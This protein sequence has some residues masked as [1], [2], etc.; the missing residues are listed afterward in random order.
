[1]KIEKEVLIGGFVGGA[2]MSLLELATALK[3]GDFQ[4]VS[5]FFFIGCLAS[6]A[7][8]IVGSLMVGPKDFRNAVSAGIAAPSLLG[9]LVGSGVATT[10]VV[11]LLNTVQPAVYAEDAIPLNRDKVTVGSIVGVETDG[12]I[13]L[14]KPLPEPSK[15]IKTEPVPMRVQKKATPVKQMMRAFGVK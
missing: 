9:G 6:G 4:L 11:A 1:M 3:S 15:V 5:I 8:G 7:I 12:T 2:A 14:H 10:V 13:T